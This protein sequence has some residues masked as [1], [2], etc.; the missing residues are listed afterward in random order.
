M[1]H[2]RPPAGRLRAFT[3]IE[4]LVVIAIIAILAA[5]LLPA[6]SKAKQKAQGIQCLSNGRQL[7]LSCQLY[8]ADYADLFP[9][10]A[11]DDFPPYCWAPGSVQGGMPGDTRPLGSCTFVPESLTSTA[12]LLAPFVGGS[13]GVF[14]CPAD[15]R[16]GKYNGSNPA[17]AGNTYPV[18]RSYSMNE[19]VG[20]IDSVFAATHTAKTHG[21]APALPTMGPWLT[22]TQYQNQ[23]NNP[24]ATFGKSS[25]FVTA[26]SA[27]VFLMIDESPWS[28]DDG[29]FG[30]CAGI[31]KW[32]NYPATFHNRACGFSFCDGHAEIHHWQGTSMILTAARPSGSTGTPVPPTDPDWLWMVAHST[33]KM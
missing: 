1:I 19:S 2:I 23:H 9:P 30:V 10:N 29:G 11:D 24:Y 28:I 8:A 20:V 14:K 15:P 18:T 13:I 16:Q 5:M 4:L 17:L 6:L 33:V 25:D 31:P 12:N 21:G 22:G 3:L 27:N 32:I 26:S 7:G